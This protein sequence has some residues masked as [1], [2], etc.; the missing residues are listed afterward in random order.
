MRLGVII[1]LLIVLI[2]GI[3]SFKLGKYFDRR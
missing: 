3:A 1:G 2:I